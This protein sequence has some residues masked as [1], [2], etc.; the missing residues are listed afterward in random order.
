MAFTGKYAAEISSEPKWRTEENRS[1]GAT[2]NT[3]HVFLFFCSLLHVHSKQTVWWAITDHTFWN[4]C[5]GKVHQHSPVIYVVIEH[6]VVTIWSDCYS[7]KV[8]KS[9]SIPLGQFKCHKF[10]ALT[11]WYISAPPKIQLSAKDFENEKI[12]RQTMQH[13]LH[14][15]LKELRKA[16]DQ[17]AKLESAVSGTGHHNDMFNLKNSV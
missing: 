15:V 1:S 2:G 17:I 9:I 11:F 3:W 4:S 13:Q 8:G 10:L 16:R 12:D 5:E 6:W 7:L 14:K